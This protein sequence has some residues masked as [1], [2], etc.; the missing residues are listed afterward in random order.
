M[1]HTP[2]WKLYENYD[3]C[4]TEI[5]KHLDIKLILDKLNFLERAV[6]VISGE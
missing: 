3:K 6:F 2:D 5:Q 1:G 4:R